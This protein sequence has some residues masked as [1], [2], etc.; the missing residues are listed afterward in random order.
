[1][2]PLLILGLLAVLAAGPMAGLAIGLYLGRRKRM[3][4]ILRKHW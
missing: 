2:N 1:M 4:P 3:P